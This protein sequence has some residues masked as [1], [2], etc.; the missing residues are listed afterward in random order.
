MDEVVRK[1][2]VKAIIVD[3]GKVLFLWDPNYRTVDKWDLPGGRKNEGESD[4]DALKRE[5]K[6]EAGIDVNVVRMIHEWELSINS[7]NWLL[8]GKTYL[9]TPITTDVRLED[10]DHQH[11]KYEWIPIERAKRLKLQKWELESLNNIKP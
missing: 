10:P 9:C 6:E 8:V 7:R 4:I 5:V 2:A 11:T 3:N 1:H